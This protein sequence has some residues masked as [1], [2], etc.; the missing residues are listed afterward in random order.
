MDE[1]FNFKY[2]NSIVEKK[3]KNIKLYKKLYNTIHKNHIK[4]FIIY[5]NNYNMSGVKLSIFYKI[6]EHNLIFIESFFLDCNYPLKYI[7]NWQNY[8]HKNF[9]N[10]NKL[11]YLDFKICYKI[12]LSEN[13]ILNLE[14]FS[15]NIIELNEQVIEKTN[16]HTDGYHINNNDFNF[17]IILWEL[18]QKDYTNI[19][20]N[21]LRSY[22]F[23]ESGGELNHIYYTN[24]YDE[25]IYLRY[26]I[27]KYC[28][29][30]DKCNKEINN[31]KE[32]NRVVKHWDYMGLVHLCNSC[33]I[34]K[35]KQEE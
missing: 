4:K 12:I 9:D 27:K 11:S 29:F 5:A 30:C 32:K 2:E 3:I 28:I 24:L 19:N 17:Q 21:N 8:D 10:F 1:I 35:N 6:T 16:K 33:Y 31:F 18:L 14:L 25:S 22:K 15:G 23:E 20:S 7:L 34:K 13:G 26:M